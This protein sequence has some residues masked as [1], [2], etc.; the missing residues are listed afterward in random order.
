MTPIASRAAASEETREAYTA[1]VIYEDG[2]A[3]TVGT[4][5]AKCPTV[6][7]YNSNVTTI[8]GNAAL[9]SSMGRTVHTRP[10]TTRSRPHSAATTRTASCT[11]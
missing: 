3:V 6:A 7:A 4:V 1:G 5:S 2:E 9:A 8:L 10:T 11:R